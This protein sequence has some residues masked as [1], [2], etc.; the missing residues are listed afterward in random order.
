[1]LASINFYD[2]ILILNQVKV[3]TANIAIKK[4]LIPISKY[5]ILQTAKYKKY[6]TELFFVKF[7]SSVRAYILK[8]ICFVLKAH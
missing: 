1:M 2:M 6:R 7:E 4:F 3:E 8:I 5:E